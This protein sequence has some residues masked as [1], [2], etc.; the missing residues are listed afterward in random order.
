MQRS[1]KQIKVQHT[2]MKIS[3]FKRQEHNLVF[4]AV[5]RLTHVLLIESTQN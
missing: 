3:K 4:Y 5:Q 1:Y 2:G